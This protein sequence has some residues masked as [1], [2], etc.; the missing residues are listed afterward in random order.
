MKYRKM[1]K[2]QDELSVL[3][4]G[5]MRLPQKNGAID[6]ERAKAQL[7]G[8]IDRGLN[9][10]D[11]AMPYHDGK[12]EPFVGRALQDGYR[13]KVKLATKLPP[14]LVKER[15]DMDIILDGQLRD[16]Q[17]EK[18]DYYLIH[19]LV[20]ESFAKISKLGVRDFLDKAK[21][22]GRIVNAGFSFHGDRDSFKEIVDAY[23]WDFCMIQLNI[24]DREFQAGL[25]GMRY[26]AAKGLGVIVMEPL[27][28]G[29][30]AKDLPKS[31]QEIWEEARETRSP[32]EWALRW[33]WD[34]E[35]VTLLL[36]GMNEERHI[37]ENLRIASEVEPQ[38]L[39]KEDLELVERVAQE[40][41]RLMKSGC[42]GCGY[43]MPCP[44]GVKIPACLG[45][46]DHAKLSGDENSARMAYLIRVTGLLD[47]K[48][49]L[50]S[51]C[52]RCGKCVKACPQNIDVPK[53]LEEVKSSFEGLRLSLMYYGA[54]L[55][56]AMKRF[57]ALRG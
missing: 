34:H 46:Y 42:T 2:T 6:E 1:E 57:F 54:R 48:S 7:R 10:V 28:G 22:D 40:Y 12:S 36:S 23:D 56:L 11:T 19:S 44:A 45:L 3:G 8:A 37:E 47:G 50:A 49:G 9:Y 35:E 17:S 16:L 14:W 20:G 21:A 31:V 39:S 13:E 29:L 4:F 51:K 5:C 33:V 55:F 26:A 18:I 53:H 52:I 24:L 30:L 43:C 32:V 15:R 27:R 38:S 25:E 41:R